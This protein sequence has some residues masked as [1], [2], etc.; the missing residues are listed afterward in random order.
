MDREGLAS[1][2]PLEILAHLAETGTPPNAI[3][4]ARISA[5]LGQTLDRMVN[6]TFPFVA[7]GGA[8][9]QFVHAPYGRGKT[10]FLKVLE[11]CAQQCGLVTAYVDCQYGQSPFKSLV[12]TYRAIAQNMM[13]PSQHRF[14]GTSGIAKV[15]EARFAGKQAKAQ[16]AL[17]KSIKADDALM[18]D[19]RNLVTSYC[20]DS[21]GGGGDEELSESLEALLAATPSYRVTLGT[22]YR[23]HPHLLRP[24]GKLGRRNAAAWLRAL[25][26]LPRV[27]GYPG[28]VVLFDET[29]LALSQGSARQRQQHLAH[30][31]TFVDHMA[32]G[33][34]RGCAVYYAVVEDFI[35]IAHEHLAA[36]SQR[37]ERLPFSEVG[38]GRNQRAVWVNLDELTLPGP[39]DKRFF[40]ELAEHIV[41][42]GNE[43]GL[44]VESG[45]RLLSEFN[46]LGA[47]C[48]ANSIHEG[49]VREYVKMAAGKVAREAMAHES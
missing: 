12:E 36:L 45:E 19:Y 30:I 6:E 21:I 1:V 18:P 5:G 41:G 44:P 46:P 15:I 7:S 17:I 22:L 34:F 28:L 23:K 40:V 2:G 24:L 9:L 29:E 42:I 27:L 26:S 43:A 31:R 4:A 35:E 14:F 20:T 13:P 10:H 48:A 3:V 49:I 8:D 32:L 38:D 16:Q 33:A 25:L 37:I 47:E 39:R 11:H